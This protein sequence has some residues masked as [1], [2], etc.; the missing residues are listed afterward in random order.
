MIAYILEWALTYTP[1]MPKLFCS[2]PGC[3]AD[4]KYCKSEVAGAPPY[5]TRTGMGPATLAFKGAYLWFHAD[6]GDENLNPNPAKSSWTGLLTCGHTPNSPHLR[7][8]LVIV[9]VS[10]YHQPSFAP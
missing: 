2:H 1:R 7:S 4:R 5:T 8:K 9:I 10:G 3:M 6:F